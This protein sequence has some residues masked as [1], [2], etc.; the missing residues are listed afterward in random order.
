VGNTIGL[1]TKY[2]PLLDKVFKAASATAILDVPSDNVEFIGANVVKYLKLDMDGLADYDNDEGFVAGGVTAS[3]ATLQLSMKRARQFEIDNMDNE[4]T[5]LQ[6]FAGTV[7]EFIR[8]KVVPEV[9]ATRF[10]RYA[11]ASNI[12]TTSGATLSSSTVVPA[13]DAAIAA[14]DDA[15]VPSEG[16]IMFMTPSIYQAIKQSN[17]ATRIIPAGGGLNR[18]F[19]SFD[20]MRVVKVPQSRFYTAVT[21]LDGSSAGQTAGGY[22]KT[23]NTGKDINFMIVHPSAVLQITKHARSRTLP[24]SVN[25]Q[26][27]A[28][29]FDYLIY[30]DAFVREN[31]ASGIYVHKKA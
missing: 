12:L 20:D 21:L 3:W 5:L 16:R 17:A 4:E 26:K 6:V 14:M 8:T 15:E 7:S 1:I 29:V 10:A 30:H 19:E 13:I 31:K 2:L 24:P 23:A 11:S 28:Y 25:K 22:T 9:D 18:N 27:D